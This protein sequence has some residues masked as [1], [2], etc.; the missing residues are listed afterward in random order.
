[1]AVVLVALALVLGG[2]APASAHAELVDTDP[3]E[4]A[5]VETA[6]DTVTLTFNEP[7]RLTSQE[8]AVYD[9]QGDPVAASAGASGEE[10]RVDLAGAADLPDG[11]YVVSWNVLSGDGHPIAGALTFSVGAP[12]ATVA[13]PP[14]PETS[15]ATVT[16]LRDVV[17][18]ATLLGLL[19]AA[20]LALFLALVLPRS[21]PGTEVRGR[22]RR[23][24]LYA[25]GAGA[26]GAV[27]Q[28]PIAS[29]Y[30]QG[31][32]LGSIVTSFDAGAVANE[33]AAAALVL[34]GLGVVVRATSAA[35]PDRAAGWQLGGGALLSL[36]GPS[37]VGHSRAFTP[38]PLL[39]ATDVLHVTAGAVWLGGLLGLV[40]TLRALAG[41]EALAAQT[42]A[43][44]ST[45]AGG[46]LLAVAATGTFLAWRIVGSWAGL[47]ETSYGW[48]LLTKVAIALV[49]A[50]VGGWNRWR[51]LPAVRAAAGFGDREHAAAAVTRTV[52]VEAVLLAVLL[53]VTGVLV[54][55]SPRPAPVTVASGTTGAGAATAGDLRVL[56][57]MDPRRTGSNTLLVQVQDAAG[58]PYDPPSNPVVA[59]RTDGLDIGEVTVRSIGAGTYRG[60]VVVPRAGEWE[61]QVSIRLSRFENP[62]T[63]VR[64]TVRP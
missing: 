38:S 40:L 17:T 42:L 22:L 9:A 15:S 1:M 33:L 41:R 10:V 8:I 32:E 24:L 19:V 14:E 48:L 37:V 2:G 36:A 4:G 64:L 20:G 58:E 53:G 30:G 7:V 57:V 21:W 45:L 46:V 5:V 47:V 59:L 43:R 29:V 51:V 23:L 54:N 26:L 18:V 11:T 56:A 39:V 34:V 6:P 27:L 28:V 61:V 60:E 63:T 16:V 62:V 13:A 49:V 3:D 52:R 31:L 35:A 25:A 50:G 12:S 44:F 55:Q